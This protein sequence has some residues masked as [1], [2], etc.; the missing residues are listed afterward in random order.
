MTLPASLDALKED[1]LRTSCAAW[2]IQKR[3]P[4]GK[5]S[6]MAGP[7]PKCGGTDRFSINARKNL[8]N[9]RG[10]GIS[11]EGVIKLVMLTEDVVFVRALEIIT[12][13]RPSDDVD[14]AK[15]DAIRQQNARDAERRDAEA[16]RYRE[17]ARKAGHDIWVS[18]WR[19]DFAAGSESVAAA[20]LRARGIVLG[21]QIGRQVLLKEYDFLPWREEAGKDERGRRRW[22]TVHTGPALLAC[23]QMPD[24]R[25]GA[26]HQTWLDLGQPKGKVVL[27]PDDKGKDRVSRKVLG[28][29]KGGAIRLYTPAGAR[30]MVMGEG[31]ETTLTPLAH[32]LEPDTAYWAGVALGNMAGRALR[33]PTGGQIWDQP[34]MDDRDSFLPPDWV[35]ELVFLADEDAADEN[36]I[37]SHSVEKAWRGLRRAEAHRAARRETDSTL[38]PLAI[39]YVTPHAADATA[40][41]VNDLV[42]PKHD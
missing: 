28:A 9:C 42:L 23:V 7:C 11:G 6:E 39:F 38:P 29:M 3:W 40:G 2:A 32:A 5:G 12:G 37:E 41:D 17:A 33:G 24:A 19:V 13:R 18:G 27:P 34:D 31:I 26:V 1:A 30:R 16:A 20:Y 22:R 35:E 21:D 10:C 25:F 14:E 8:F 15:A 4:L 36:G